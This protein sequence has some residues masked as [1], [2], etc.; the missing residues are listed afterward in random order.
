MCAATI[1]MAAEFR[2]LCEFG[3]QQASQG[4]F[5]TAQKRDNEPFNVAGIVLPFDG[6]IPV[7]SATETYISCGG[8]DDEGDEPTEHTRTYNYYNASTVLSGRAIAAQGPESRM[9]G[10]FIAMINEVG[11]N[12]IVTLC[13]EGHDYWSKF[14]SETEPEVRFDIQGIKLLKRTLKFPDVERSITHYYL[15]KWPDGGTVPPE[16]LAQTIQAVGNVTGPL[17]V[18]CI[19]GIGRTGTF[20]AAYGAYLDPGKD[21]RDITHSLR[22]KDTGRPRM[23]CNQEQLQLAYDTAKIVGR[24]SADLT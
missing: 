17:L 15:D 4:S 12:A 2:A 5:N 18:H 21:I 7:F 11:V 22:A 1:D 3:Q 14:S 6:T 20:L 8:S 13:H 10:A 16:V 24:D 23:I 9:L 19:A